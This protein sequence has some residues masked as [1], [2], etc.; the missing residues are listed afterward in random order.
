MRGVVKPVLVEGE[1][2]WSS[3]RRVGG[4]KYEGD[5]VTGF[6]RGVSHARV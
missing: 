5:Q 4:E 3:T 6:A 1:K 2:A